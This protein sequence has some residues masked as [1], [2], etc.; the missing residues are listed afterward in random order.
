MAEVYTNPFTVTLTAN[1]TAGDTTLSVS[2]AAPVAIQ[3]GTFRVRLANSSNTVLKVTAGAATLT[4]TVAAEFNDANASSGATVY[5]CE[6]SPGALTQILADKV[7][8]AISNGPDWPPSSANTL[9]D[10]F[11]AASLDAKWT[12]VNQGT[13]T[14]TLANSV[15][16]ITVPTSGSANW[17]YIYQTAPGSTPWELQMRCAINAPPQSNYNNAGLVL[18]DSSGKFVFF[19][20]QTSLQLGAAYWNSPTTISTG[21]G[22]NKVNFYTPVVYLKANDDGTNLTFWYSILGAGWVQVAQV[23][24]TAFLTS[25]P[26]RV[27]FGADTESGNALIFECDWFRRTL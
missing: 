15:C 6:F 17:R 19:G 16:A 14:S 22:T 25:G 13:A 23:A 10:D 4:W 18:S 9:D 8:T 21:V 20:L 2:G 5:G 11:T 24:R 3:T 7:P 12:W 27:G 1:Y 26:T